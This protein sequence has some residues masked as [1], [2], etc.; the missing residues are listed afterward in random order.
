M[1]WSLT[2]MYGVLKDIYDVWAKIFGGETET[3]MTTFATSSDK[4]TGSS[5][6]LSGGL[7]EIINGFTGLKRLPPRPSG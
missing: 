7:Q 5:K 3:K 6:G 1:T 4:A 2:A